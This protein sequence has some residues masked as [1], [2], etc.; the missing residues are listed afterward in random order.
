LHQGSGQG[1]DFRIGSRPD[2]HDPGGKVVDLG[3][4]AA[5]GTAYQQD[6]QRL[7]LEAGR[8]PQQRPQ[9][10]LGYVCSHKRGA[11][12]FLQGMRREVGK[13]RTWRAGKFQGGTILS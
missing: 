3:V 8:P 5:M 1:G 13:H 9:N 11:R 4:H 12:L 10:C 6:L 7:A 2:G